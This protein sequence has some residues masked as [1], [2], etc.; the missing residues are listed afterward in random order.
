[1]RIT[2]LTVVVL[3]A[4]LDEPSTP[5]YGY[6]L[7][8]ACGLGSA[9]LYPILDQLERA[10]WLERERRSGA[11]VGYRLTAA[12]QRSA[13]MELARRPSAVGL[14]LGVLRPGWGHR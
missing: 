9:R 5:R 11:R 12:G 8:R 6:D 2:R 3:R 1:M 4:F 10:G 7:M 13:R 14:G